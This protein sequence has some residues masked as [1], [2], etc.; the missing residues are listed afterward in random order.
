MS[1]ITLTEAPF[2]PKNSDVFTLSVTPVLGSN[3]E[4]TRGIF[5]QIKASGIKAL[6]LTG[7]A[8]GTVPDKLNPF[9]K[10]TVE[11]GVPVFVL[12]T[13]PADAKGPQRIKY[14]SQE[15]VLEAGAKILSG[16]NVNNEEEV[17][18]AVQEAI[19]EGKTGEE[20]SQAIT[21]RFGTPEI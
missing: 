17:A 20:L 3:Q 21:D 15:K 19:G 9:I 14:E 16:V 2:E 4:L 6:I 11:R 7:Y 5:D 1:E 8:T 10:E 13:N 18:K 12:S